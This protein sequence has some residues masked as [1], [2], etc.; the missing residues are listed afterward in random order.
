MS[1]ANKLKGEVQF[2]ALGQRWTMLMDFNAICTLEDVLG[3]KGTDF[4]GAM[5]SARAIRTTVLVG[6]SEHHP[7]IDEKTVGK[8]LTDLGMDRPLEI[9]G[10]AFRWAMPEDGEDGEAGADPQK[11][12]ASTGTISS[13]PGRKPTSAR[14]KASGARPRASS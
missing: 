5:T 11:A 13:R 7:E 4:S 12:E 8:I 6:L 10:E 1:V 2:L 14:S 3:V 9:I